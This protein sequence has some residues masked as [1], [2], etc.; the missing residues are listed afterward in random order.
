MKKLLTCI[1]LVMASV[2]T[3]AACSGSAPQ[4][5]ASAPAPAEDG[6]KFMT[7]G[8][9]GTYYR[10]GGVLAEK[11]AETTGTKLNVTASA[12]SKENIEAVQSGDA[13]F[14]FCQSDVLAYAVEGTRIFEKKADKVTA[15]ADLYKEQIQIITMDPTLQSVA[16]LKGKNVS[17]GA[18]GS[19]V[20]FNAIDVLEAYGLTEKDITPSYKSFGD[21]VDALQSGKIDAAFVVAGAPTSAVSGL[22]ATTD[23]YLIGLDDEHIDKLIAASPHYTKEVISSKTYNTAGDINTV[24]VG[25]VLIAN[26]DVSEDEVYNVISGIYENA[27][28]ITKAH[29]KGAE[30]NV[31]A[32]AAITSAPYHS[33]AAKYFGEKGITVK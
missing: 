7:G 1:A 13:K 6:L 12:G 32:A 14:A 22:A 3:L 28:A 10:F 30:L 19:G 5:P 26:A 31:E 15:I 24:A 25:A 2:I 18:E 21:S 20:Y 23:V 16:D 8:E 9:Q 33:G 17:I 29:S 27:D 11:I 4:A